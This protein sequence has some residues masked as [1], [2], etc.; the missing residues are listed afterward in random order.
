MRNRPS[1]TALKVARGV[2]W[3]GQV[4]KFAPLLP[5]GAA[6]RTRELLVAGGFH[7]PWHDRVIRMGWHRRL[8]L[9]SSDLMVPGQLEMVALRK[10]FVQDEV[11][12]A[13]A[14]GATQVLVVGAGFD[15]LTL[16]LAP[17]HPDVAFFEVDHPPTQ[18]AK[19]AAAEAYGRLAPNLHFLPADLTHATLGS[20]LRANEAW[21]VTARS[22]VVAEGV[23]MYLDEA[24]VSGFFAEVRDI[25][26]PDSRVVFSHV[27]ADDRGRARLGKL[28]WLTR[29]SLRMMGEPMLWAINDLDPFLAAHG[30]E[31]LAPRERSE[32]GT[33]YGELV[34]WRDPSEG[35]ERFA[36]VTFAD[37]A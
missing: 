2:I 18:K 11:C 23:L 5:E 8:V 37:P 6:A 7:K 34:P 17:E 21:S 19:C 9:W 25:A 3:M 1:Y 22:I 13:I 30:L 36:I 14:A 4:P 15:T 35:I 12:D 20:I 29:G 16:R 24:D 32:M 31:R 26:G 28:S 10:R 27:G 33:R